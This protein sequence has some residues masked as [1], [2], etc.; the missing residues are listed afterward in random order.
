[1]APSRAWLR[2]PGAVRTCVQCFGA[3]RIRKIHRTQRAGTMFWMTCVH[4][5]YVFAILDVANGDVAV[6]KLPT[7]ASVGRW[8]LPIP[9]TAG[10][11]A[12]Y[13]TTGNER[14]VVMLMGLYLLEY[15]VR[16]TLIWE[17]R[18]DQYW[19]H[20]AVAPDHWV[21]YDHHDPVSPGLRVLVPHTTRVC[22]SIPVACVIDVCVGRCYGSQA[23]V[24]IVNEE[25]G[26]W[27]AARRVQVFVQGA[28]GSFHRQWSRALS[29]HVTKVCV[30]RH[31]IVAL[32]RLPGLHSLVVLRAADG[33]ILYDM[34]CDAYELL[35][36]PD[37]R[38]I[39]LD[40]AG[41]CLTFY[42]Q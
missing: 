11:M 35:V 6:Y 9:W 1:M 32:C 19:K 40:E 8:E 33:A 34:R 29:R 13:G 16:G 15:D 12:A 7:G 36:T 42:D 10:G 2:V 22:G 31:Q 14:V 25:F 41:Q 28:T 37:Q 5:E 20:L 39:L 21:V 30:W 24:A 23:I 4:N 26:G 27:P 18:I 38:L 17:M 3:P